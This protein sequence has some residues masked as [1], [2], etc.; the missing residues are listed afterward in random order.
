MK[1]RI[2]EVAIPLTSGKYIAFYPQ[3]EEKYG[4][5]VGHLWWRKYITGVR[6]YNLRREKKSGV[7]W[8]MIGTENDYG[9]VVSCSTIEEARKVIEDYRQ[10]NIEAAYKYCEKI[11]AETEDERFVKYHPEE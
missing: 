11:G 4:E 9:Q 1:S 8:G 3:V 10:Q 5:F 2:K 6:W 7:L